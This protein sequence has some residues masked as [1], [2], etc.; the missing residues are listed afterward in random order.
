MQILISIQSMLLCPRPFFNEPGC[1]VETDSPASVAYNKE[2][3]LQ[4]AR[5]AICD[6][7][8]PTTKNSLWKVCS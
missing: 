1:G 8:Q 6:W 4:T 5:L 3:A 2:V 7:M